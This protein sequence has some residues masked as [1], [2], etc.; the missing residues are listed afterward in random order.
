MLL[1]SVIA[2]LPRI[3]D[4]QKEAMFELHSHYFA[5]V[6][7]NVFLDDMNGKDWIILLREEGHIV[8]FS[9]L[10]L[11][12][13]TVDGAERLFLFSGDTIVDRAH[14]QDSTLAGC[15]GHFM[16][17]LMTEHPDLPRYWFLISKGYR[18][19]RFLPVYFKRFYPACDRPTPPAYAALLDAVATRKF[20]PAYDT[21]AGIVRSGSQKDRLRPEMCGIPASRRN[22]PHVRFFLER[23]PSYG[24]GDELAC[25]ADIARENLNRYAWRVIEHTAVEW[26]E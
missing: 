19:Y 12:R 11:L 1:S 6:R 20:G 21:T 22:D 25:I 23:N 7:R 3:T 2:K 26:D 4:C 16:L 10:Q 8:G 14:W 13:L 9:T 24:Q 5:N 18:T 17:R 15:F